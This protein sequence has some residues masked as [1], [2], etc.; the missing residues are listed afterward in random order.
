LQ[1]RESYKKAVAAETLAGEQQKVAR[2][3]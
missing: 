3:L 1:A 2:R